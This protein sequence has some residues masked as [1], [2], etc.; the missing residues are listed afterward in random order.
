MKHIKERFGQDALILDTR[1]RLSRKPGSIELCEEVEVEIGLD[2]RGKTMAMR[3]AASVGRDRPMAAA[4]PR[5][6]A[7]EIDRFEILVGA[8]EQQAELL[9]GAQ[10]NWPLR[11]RFERL[12]LWPGVIAELSE[13]FGNSVPPANQNDPAVAI[14]ELRRQLRCVEDMEIGSLRGRHALLGPPG[15]GKSVLAAKLAR[16]IAG[17]RGKA[18]LVSY[19]PEHPGERVR[20]EELAASGGFETVIAPDPDGLRSAI[21]Y[22]RDS[23]LIVVDMPP[24]APGQLELLESIESTGQREP[25]LR[26]LVLAADGGWRRRENLLTGMDFLALSRCDLAEPL[27]PA[28]ELSAVGDFSLSFLSGSR[29][30]DRELKLAQPDEMLRVLSAEPP[31]R[32]LKADSAEAGGRT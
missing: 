31:T 24:I 22:L 7:E 19:A 30:T 5:A 16:A 20:L 25:L 1:T 13:E 21:N 10:Q 12:G 27:L 15:A 29:E 26:H 17:H 3:E 6:M 23:D 14:S 4:S 2:K 11:E 8:L 28:L 18:V 9:P 32:R